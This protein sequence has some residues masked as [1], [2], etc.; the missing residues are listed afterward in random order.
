MNFLSLFVL[1]PL[2][3]MVGLALSK[4]MKTDTIGSRNR[5]SHSIII[6]NRFSC[7]LFV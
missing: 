5:F 2:L 6:S 3:M 1:I 7:A 4:E